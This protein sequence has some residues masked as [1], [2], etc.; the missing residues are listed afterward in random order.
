MSKALTESQLEAFKLD[1]CL[2]AI[3]ALTAQEAERFRAALQEQEALMGGRLKRMD[4]CHLFFRWAYD[5]ATHPAVLD[6][7]EDVLG[8]NLFVH[9]TRVFYKHPYDP[10]YVS[11]HQDGTYSQLN[12]KP[13]PSAWI[14]LTDSSVENGC[15]R[16]VPGSHRAGKL[17][18]TE[19]YADDNL[20][21]HGEEIDVAVAE[22]SAR[23]MVLRPGE[24]SLHH[25]NLIHGSKPNRSGKK[26]IGFAVTYVTPEV[27]RS[28]L[29]VVWARGTS[30]DHEFDLL[31][32][33]PALSLAEAI[34]AHSEFVQ[35][36]GL[37]RPR[38]AAGF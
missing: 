1:G 11:W 9:S 16:V 30:Q 35:G 34:R 10:A 12:S 5:L 37:Q 21:N 36:N 8:P 13:A 23:D 33:P 18:H 38:V 4:N 29:P 32:L 27:G 20:L 17:S 6:V 28:N 19:T 22:A 2:S 26:R 7:M 14:A 25:V 31:Q 15:L 24:M 3:P